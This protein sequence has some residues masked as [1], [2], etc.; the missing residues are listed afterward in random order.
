MISIQEQWTKQ[1]CPIINGILFASGR[2]AW[3]NVKEQFSGRTIS[4]ELDHPSETSI[5]DLLEEDKLQWTDLTILKELNQDNL[6]LLVQ[7]GEGAMGGDGFVASSDL[8]SKKLFWIAFFE[9]SNPFVDIRVTD[10][11]IQAINNHSI[12]WE[13]P[14]NE[15]ENLKIDKTKI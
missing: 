6:N 4:Y 8:A 13:F 9:N 5:T 1:R 12:L 7:A 11:V 2:I 3:I 15:P 10:D 14:I